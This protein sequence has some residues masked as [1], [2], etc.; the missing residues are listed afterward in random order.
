MRKLIFLAAAF[1]IATHAADSNWKP[2]PLFKDGKIDPNW[3]FIGYGKFVVDGDAIKTD[4]APEGLG[5]LVYKKEK[6][7][8]CQIRVVFKTREARSNS[9]F[10]VRMNDG[11]LDQVKNP[12]AKF[13]RD[14]NGKISEASDKKMQES[15]EKEEGPWYGVHQGYEVQ[16][17]GGGNDP[18]H[19]TASIYSLAPAGGEKKDAST[20]WKTM[21]I[22]LDGEKIFVDY[23]GERVTTFDAT[24]PNLPERKI[25]HAPKR[26][27]KRPQK[28]Y[29][30][31]Q[32]HDPGDEVWFK[33]IAVRPLPGK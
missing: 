6:F 19:G 18:S 5:L 11:I 13:D 17:A 24:A 15:S 31:L 29:I 33:E 3:A 32:T 4:P 26:E 27:H 25:W 10:Y 28:G 1:C 2:L 22:T 7:G 8:N 14:A 9:G 30:G 12:G 20:G 23:E 16:I 21:V